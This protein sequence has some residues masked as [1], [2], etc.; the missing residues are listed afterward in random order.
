MLE[1]K[2]VRTEDFDLVFPTRPTVYDSA[3]FNLLNAPKAERVSALCGFSAE[4]KPL[5]GQIFGLRDGLWRA[6]FSAPFSA[7]SVNCREC[8][9][10]LISEFYAKVPAI[11]G[12]NLR[13]VWP[14]EFYGTGR[15]PQADE[16]LIDANFHYD[17]TRFADFE[18]HLSRSGRYSHHRALKHPFDFFKTTDVRRAY[19]VIEANRRAMGYPLA[20]S[21]EQVLATVSGPVHA[22]F[23]VLTLDGVDIAAAMLYDAAPSVMQVIY[24]GDLPQARPARAMNHLA[25]RVFSWYA[26]NRPDIR[27][28]DIGPA[29]SDGVRNEGLCRFKLSLGCIETPRPTLTINK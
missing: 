12:G 25:W 26:A 19:A 3:A 29:S 7:A 9:E 15:P 10:S 6:P 14:S 21:L 5:V 16:V 20:M 4:G 1:I 17:M 11:L 18:V 2:P 24:W 27:I 23:F 13:L 22:D 8:R 28:I